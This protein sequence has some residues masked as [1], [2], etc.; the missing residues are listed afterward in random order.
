MVDPIGF[1]VE[2]AINPH[3]LD[4]SGRLNQI[5]P[6]KARHQWEA[7]KKTF[8]TLGLEV[9]TFPGKSDFPDMTFCANQ[10]FPIL[11]S[12]KK[13]S[14]IM[15][16]MKN[17][18]RKGE[19]NYFTDWAGENGFRTFASPEFI[20]EGSGD[21]IWNYETGEIYGGYGFRTEEA[22]YAELERRFPMK[23]IRVPLVN[24]EFYHLDTC[25]AVL[26]SNIAAYVE[27]AFNAETITMLRSK[28]KILIRIPYAEAKKFFAGNMCGVGERHVVLQEGAVSTIVGLKYAGLDVI[29]V[30]TS[31]F[32]KAGGS[33]FCLKQ[34]LF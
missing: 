18:P 25:F 26:R 10:T 17:D 21:A 13:P 34:F 28:F 20:F 24:E 31:E 3:M 14:V 30:D 32:I 16:K 4:S 22:A 27:E 9:L 12:R 7:L 33:V 15:G 19:V 5:D 1:R 11:D 23:F 6:A 29:E 8:Q 2:Y